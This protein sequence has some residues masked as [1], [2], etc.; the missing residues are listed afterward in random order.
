MKNMKDLLC[1]PFVFN[2]THYEE[3]RFGKCTK[4]ENIPVKIVAN[5]GGGYISFR[6]IG[7]FNL[8]IEHG[9]A[10]SLNTAARLEDRVQY[11]SMDATVGKSTTPLACNLFN[12]KTC[13]R[14]GLQSPLRVVEFYGT[15]IET[16][17]SQVEKDAE[18]LVT[19]FQRGRNIDNQIV[20]LLQNIKDNPQEL[21]NVI[22]PQVMAHAMMV[23]LVSNVL[24]DI[25]DK[26][27][28]AMIGYWCLSRAIELEPNNDN[29]YAD[30]VSLMKM[31]FEGMKWA[32]LT[33]L[34]I[35]CNP[36]DM[37]GGGMSEMAARDAVFQMMAADVYLHP[38]ICSG[39]TALAL[40]ND[41]DTKI[42][43]NFFAPLNTWVQ[44]AEKGMSYHK[45]MY[46]ILSSRISDNDFDI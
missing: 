24:N 32:A 31:G 28:A 12:N 7:D 2:A 35:N 34:N 18:S 14:F 36:Y 13:V 21:E 45:R 16:E 43:Q 44:L 19:M 20:S 33:C 46:K 17:F 15:Y 3:W 40:K 39:R 27:L 8:N 10:M 5:I 23:A 9:F 37:F 4:N 1:K 29:L 26:E 42:S 25:D 38:N 41:L 30:R 6:L 22:N 11:G